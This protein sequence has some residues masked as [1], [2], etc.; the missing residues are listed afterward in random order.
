M[1]EDAELEQMR[2][3]VETCFG[4]SCNFCEKDCPVYKVKKE[5]TYTSRGKNRSIL[6]VL[7]GKVKPSEELA[8]L[9]Y[10]CL[11]CASCDARCAMENNKRFKQMRALL[12]KRGLARK[13]HKELVKAV[14]ETG[15]VYGRKIDLAKRFEAEG[16]D[17]VVPLYIGCQYKDSADDVRAVVRVLNAVGIKPVIGEEFCCGYVADALGFGEELKQIKERNQKVVTYKDFITV[18]PTCTHYFRSE[19]G[20]APKHVLEVV[21]ANLD[22]LKWKRPRGADG[23]K[24]RVTWHDPCDL[25]RRLKLFEEPRKILGAMGVELVEMRNSGPFSVCCG[26]GGGM[27]STDRELSREMAKNRMRQAAE[28]GAEVLVTCCPTCELSLLRAANAIGK[29]TKRKMEVVGLYR[30]MAD[31]LKA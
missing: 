9:F 4:T 15:D 31:H 17:G 22:K 1:P 23:K 6:G 3:D 25:G 27:L 20:L 18:C 29:E 13:E 28:T 21:A 30:F 19:Y 14:L 26:A 10:T 7:E 12:V 24:L 16:K 11:L 8:K 2:K 5:K